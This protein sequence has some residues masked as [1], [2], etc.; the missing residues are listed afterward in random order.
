MIGAVRMPAP[1]GWR[2]SRCRKLRPGPLPCPRPGRRALC[3][4]LALVLAFGQLGAAAGRA[5]A[6]A[7][8]SGEVV[9]KSPYAILM[10]ADSG[11]VLYQRN[12][13]EKVP[14]R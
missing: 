6:Q 11:A 5:R 2:P 12:A 9:L 13:D 10:D 4:A 3:L 1:A 14:P 8:Q 7:Q